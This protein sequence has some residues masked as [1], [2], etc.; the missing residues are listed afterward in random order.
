MGNLSAF[1]VLRC[2]LGLC[3]LLLCSGQSSA[4][5]NR[6]I[7]SGEYL[8]YVIYFGVIHGGI[9][10]I[11]THDVIYNNNY[12]YHSMVVANTVGLA[13]K[14][15]HVRDIYQSIFDP[16][17][18]LPY[19]SLREVNEGKYHKE[20]A[21]WFFQD[22]N[23]VRS[24]NTGIVDSLPDNLRDVVSSLYYLREYDFDTL[25]I[26]EIIKIN[27]FFDE[28]LYHFD[29]RYWGKETIKTKMG[30]YNCIK[31]VPYVIAGRAFKSED[32]MT[33]WLCPDLKYA[34]VRVK[35][36]LWV[37]SIKADLINYRGIF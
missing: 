30:E 4:K 6:D 17:S 22:K 37:G 8:E 19:K 9:A 35:F 33:V 20:N 27:T 11:T 28:E 24:K 34:P 21:V 16:E 2:L 14:L 31:L 18:T 13:N 36:D 29:M 3:I 1:G 10:T 12:A 7:K 5:V 15:Y 25:E 23:S 26:G 32:D